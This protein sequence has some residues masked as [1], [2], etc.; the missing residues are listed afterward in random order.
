[1][2]KWRAKMLCLLYAAP[3]RRLLTFAQQPAPLD[4]SRMNEKGIASVGTLS[5][6]HLRTG[7][8]RCLSHFTSVQLH[9]LEIFIRI[10]SLNTSSRWIHGSPEQLFAKCA[11]PNNYLHFNLGK[12]IGEHNQYCN[13]R[14]RVI[15]Y[16]SSVCLSKAAVCQR[17]K[18]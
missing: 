1:M 8:G 6:C 13:D 12:V 5:S 14:G 7:S 3:I 16:P 11:P 4:G 9:I 18:S 2:A 10:W 15:S 17:W